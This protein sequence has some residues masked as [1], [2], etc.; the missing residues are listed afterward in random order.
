MKKKLEYVYDDISDELFKASVS[1]LMIFQSFSS[2]F[3]SI[4]FVNVRLFTYDI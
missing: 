2:N 1:H 3:P 4:F